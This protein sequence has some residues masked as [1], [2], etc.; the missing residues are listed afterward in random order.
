MVHKVTVAALRT[1]DFTKFKIVILS[2][3]ALAGDGPR[4]WKQLFLGVSDS[5]NAM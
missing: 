3:I 2:L 5:S 1:T 4:S